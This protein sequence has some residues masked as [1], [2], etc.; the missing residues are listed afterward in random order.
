[1]KAPASRVVATTR[2]AVGI[3]IIGVA[4][5]AVALIGA[6]KL[7]TVD[8]KPVAVEQSTTQNSTRTL[9]CDGSYAELGADEKHPNVA[10]PVGKPGIVVAGET[11]PLDGLKRP[12]GGDG[13]PAV[14]SVAEGASGAAAQL[15][16]VKSK[17]VSGAVASTCAE[18]VNEQW[19][20]GGAS[21][22]GVTTTLNLANPGAVSANAQIEVFDEIGPVQQVRSAGIIVAP[23]T[24]QTVSLNGYAPD[25]T[26]LAVRV[27]STGAPVT[28][29][30]GVGHRVGLDS[31]GVSTVDRQ[32]GDTTRLVIA[33]LS[34]TAAEG[35]QASDA[36]EGDPYP[37]MVRVLAV[38]GATGTA[39]V[40][41]LDAKGNATALGSIELKAGAVGE[42]AVKTW[43]QAAQAIVI[44][45][46]TEIVG[47]A[48]GSA[49]K[50]SDHDY[51]WL[52][53][54]AD[55]A[56]HTATPL[57]V[58]AGA[59][60]VVAHPGEGTAEVTVTDPKGK[61]T[62]Y[63]LGAHSALPITAANGS[64][65]VADDTVNIGVRYVSGVTIAGYPV[66]PKLERDGSL[67]VFTR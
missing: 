6:T 18:P 28:A 13:L 33:G 7:P 1:M 44:T 34:N 17:N 9:V 41:A 26:R 32:I 67:T 57:P 16:Q 2:V 53:P 65:L 21:S 47:G 54:A 4:A 60:V 63:Q 14:F 42:L 15:Q 58:V 62:K 38:N 55:I 12:V 49:G 48:L 40:K 3:V 37:V 20:V 45:A 5:S 61:D 51:E 64:V 46:D 50:G 29:A 8:V 31:F 22:L 10:V 30:L 43:P 23:G 35:E 36:G 27:T 66:Q 52:A 19:L 25:R 56:A 59:T 11:T 24:Q 39:S